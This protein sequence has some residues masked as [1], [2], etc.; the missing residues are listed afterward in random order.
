MVM[1]LEWR[2]VGVHGALANQLA[3]EVAVT[4]TYT[5]PAGDIPIRHCGPADHVSL[6]VEREPLGSER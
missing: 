3:A 2:F 1:R 4:D 5:L 6:G